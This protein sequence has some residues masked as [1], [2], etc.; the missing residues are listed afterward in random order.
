MQVKL[1][2]DAFN[3]AGEGFEKG[4]VVQARPSP[5]GDKTGV[6]LMKDGKPVVLGFPASA[7][8]VVKP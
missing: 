2:K 4:E 8:E 6:D 3:Y 5:Y 7:C 1:K